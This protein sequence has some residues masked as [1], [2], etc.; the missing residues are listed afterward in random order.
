MNQRATAL[1]FAAGEG[2]SSLASILLESGAD[3]EIPDV[4]GRTPLAR[5][6]A[7]S[8][9]KLIELLLKYKAEVDV[10]DGDGYTALHFAAE[11]GD[12]E[13]AQLLLKAGDNVVCKYS[14]SDTCC[15]SMLV[16]VQNYL[17]KNTN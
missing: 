9:T 12:S 6:A 10:K 2:Q 7:A 1:G 11:T 8:E 4:N 17:K 13:G 3:L 5:A 14:I 15:Q 16:Q